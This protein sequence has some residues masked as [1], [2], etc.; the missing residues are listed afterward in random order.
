M[1]DL[2][3]QRRHVLLQPLHLLLESVLVLFKDV[4][5]LSCRGL[6]LAAKL[7]KVVNLR[8]RHPRFA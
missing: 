6:S 1:C 8:E 3:L 5:A 7:G 4:Q 2:V